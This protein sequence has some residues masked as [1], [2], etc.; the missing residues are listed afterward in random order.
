MVV[1]YKQS[2][3]Q[4][5]KRP[6]IQ[7]LLDSMTSLQYIISFMDQMEGMGEEQL[8]YNLKHLQYIRTKCK[9]DPER[10]KFILAAESYVQSMLGEIKTEMDNLIA[11]RAQQAISKEKTLYIVDHPSI[12]GDDK[13]EYWALTNWRPQQYHNAYNKQGKVLAECN[14]YGFTDKMPE[15]YEDQDRIIICLAYTIRNTTASDA[16]K[17]EKATL[18]GQQRLLNETLAQ[19]IPRRNY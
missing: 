10:C 18:A 3:A 19:L 6:F 15:G 8:L 4:K 1:P 16:Y 11:L 13:R 17:G 5:A 9:D 2:T 12:T 7:N 14:E